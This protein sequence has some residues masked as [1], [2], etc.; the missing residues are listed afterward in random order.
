[1]GL[2]VRQPFTAEWCVPCF[3]LFMEV[4]CCMVKCGWVHR[5]I[6]DGNVY[7]YE[8]RGLIGDLEYAKVI[9]S[10]RTSDDRTVSRSQWQDLACLR[11]FSG[12][13]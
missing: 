13:G 4:I 10:G 8:G 11:A 9:G 6:S 12:N 7:I 5:Y 2:R 1:M 3:D